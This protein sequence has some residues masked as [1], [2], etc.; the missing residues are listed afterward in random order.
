MHHEYRRILQGRIIPSRP[1][2]RSNPRHS[3]GDKPVRAAYREGLQGLE[4]QANLI[5]ARQDVRKTS[6]AIVCPGC[7]KL[8]DVS[9]PRCPN[10]GRVRPG[11]FGFG[12]ALGSLFGSLSPTSLIV[13]FCVLLYM[14]SLVIDL[15]G[16]LGSGGILS[17]LSPSSR[18]LYVLG[19]TGGW[20]SV[21]GHWWTV[22][23]AIYLHGGLLHILFNV[24]WIRSLGP[25]VEEIYG[26]ARAFLLFTIAGIGGYVVSNSL[27]GAPTIGASGAIFGQLGALVAHG[28]R[29]G[30]S[31]MSRQV[32]MWAVILFAFGFV[33]RGVNNYAHAGGFAAQALGSG[34]RGGQEGPGSQVLAVIAALASVLAVILSVATTINAA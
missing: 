24:L 31:Y 9:E 17:L 19:M 3:W 32:L 5:L 7:G 29:S 12:P 11:M 16:A 27:S 1:S 4:R 6:G 15:R 34:V 30:R 21:Q 23:S 2:T 28:H 8:I 10:C 20:A 18:A 22:A 14:V 33:M 26:P 13:G 25:A